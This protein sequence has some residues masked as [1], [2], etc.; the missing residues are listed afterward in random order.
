MSFIR[1]T[2]ASFLAL[3]GAATLQAEEP[4]WWNKEWTARKPITIDPT[5]AS[6]TD[7]GGPAVILFRFSD[8]NFTFGAAKEDGSDLRF[9]SEDHRTV[10]SAQIEKWDSLYNEGYV[11]VRIPK[12]AGSGPTKLW[13]YYSQAPAGGVVPAAPDPKKTWDDKTA[14]VY[15]FAENGPPADAT[16]NA[17]NGANAGRAVLNGLIGG[18]LALDGRGSIKFPGTPALSW[19][20]SGPLTITC[21]IKPTALGARQI[22]LSRRDG[23][24]AL[25]IGLE[26][27]VPFIEVN[28]QKAS[29]S[30]ALPVKEWR[31]LGI[32]GAS[33]A[34]TLYLNGQSAASVTVPLPAG[35]GDL[36]LGRDGDQGEGF[37]GE[38]DEL[39]IVRDALTAG[40]LGLAFSTQGGT[41]AAAKILKIGDEE[42][43]GHGGTMEVIKEHLSIFSDIAQNL[44]FDGWAVIILCSLLAVVGWGISLAKFFYLNKIA[45]ASAA[46]LKQWETLS[47]DLTALD[48]SNEESIQSLGGA[49]SGKLQ[50]L[51]RQSPLYHLYHLG[52]QEIKSR[53]ENATT[54]FKGLSARSIQAIRATLDG[55]Q[56]R[57]IQRLNGK[58]VF[59]TIGIA[60]GPYLGLL[61]TVIGV[62]ITFAVIAKTGEVEVNSIAPGI[63]GALLATVAGLAVAIPALFAYSYLSSR[64]KDAVSDM[65]VFIDEFVARIAEA[66][67]STHE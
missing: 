29:A 65:Q 11:W 48:H 32:V 9:V 59:L 49:A 58:L 21:W 19:A 64:I 22:L 55:G 63:A 54:G 14:A 61:G 66:Y 25:L 41:D 67:P 60:G 12:V 10:L 17:T 35:V 44:T 51:I 7:A 53:I 62:M 42:L 46:F 28:G 57:E 56:V 4:A 40:Q 5:S 20:A 27:G 3:F 31:H 15:H 8:Q 24:N 36:F 39:Q 26:N 34:V 33:G 2:L 23:A 37:S 6:T 18:G 13:L 16:S 50:K 43:P 30:A 52:S 45:K 1:S 47:T 38:I